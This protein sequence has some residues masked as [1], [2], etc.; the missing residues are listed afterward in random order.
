MFKAKQHYRFFL[1]FL[2]IIVSWQA[3]A[4]VSISSPYSRFGIG[5]LRGNKNN[6][7]LFSMGGIRNAVNKPWIVNHSN[8]ATYAAFDSTSFI[9]EA[10]LFSNYSNLKTTEM[11]ENA[12]Y[13]SLDHILLG[14]PINRWWKSSIGIMPLSNIGYQI[15]EVRNDEELGNVQTLVEGDGG[16]T[17]FYWGNAFTVFEGFSL[18]INAFYN[19]GNIERSRAVYFPDSLYTRLNTRLENNIRVSDFSFKFGALYVRDLKNAMKISAGASFGFESNLSS[20]R[21][22]LS[23]TFLGGYNTTEEFKDTV[24][25]TPEERGN[26]TYP[27]HIGVGFVI[28]KPMHW[29]AGIDFNW[30]NWEKYRAFGYSDSLKNS[31][32]IAFGGQYIPDNDAVRGYFKRVAYRFGARF[33]N[34]YLF[35]HDRQIGEFGISFGLGLPLRRS[36]TVLNLGAEFGRRGTT[37]DNLIQE[38]FVK[39]TFSISVYERWFLRRKY[40]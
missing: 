20:K 29:L 25:Y 31:F 26:I 9:F 24:L 3:R 32:D 27:A 17:Q 7:A 19:F 21:E 39:F 33:A 40:D 34:T 30:Q 28:E 2:I 13:V 18:G 23:H 36:K 12:S 11:S 8:P 35:L 22:Y 10:G 1:I 16:I 15:L 5:D 14:F 38:N 37:A 4:Q 6:V